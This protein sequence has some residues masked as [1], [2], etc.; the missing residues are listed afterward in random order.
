MSETVK[1]PCYD[2][3][4]QES[5]ELSASA[6]LFGIEPNENAVHF[7]CEGQRFRF[8]KKT[9]KT[10]GRADVTA[11]TKKMRR[12]KGSGTGRQGDKKAPHWV[13]GGIAFGPKN[14]KRYFKVNKKLRRLALA[15]LLSD[16]HSG[17]QV[18]VLKDT[19]SE[20]KT[21][22]FVDWLSKLS[23]TNARVGFVLSK[24][25]DKDVS[26]AKSVRNLK[27]VDLLT[28]EKWT[29]LDFIKTDCIVFS[30]TALQDLT[31]QFLGESTGGKA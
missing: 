5:G 14:E 8:Y 12:Q 25:D 18:R 23:L 20:P 2:I 10:L 13:G 17:G 24:D 30:E 3:K 1:I 31:Q 15:S 29:P 27:H 26:L 4:G 16:R 22:I 7:V 19:V 9:A 28:Q 6:S 11:S 21:K